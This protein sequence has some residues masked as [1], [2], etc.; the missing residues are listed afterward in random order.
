[1]LLGPAPVSLLKLLTPSSRQ[2]AAAGTGGPFGGPQHR[3]NTLMR[4]CRWVGS[5]FA[6]TLTCQ[7][8][9]LLALGKRGRAAFRYRVGR[10]VGASVMG[11]RTPPGGH[12]TGAWSVLR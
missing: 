3:E 4:L 1:M 7:V 8:D 9:P 2:M 11:T 6:G 12:V 5:W 10:S